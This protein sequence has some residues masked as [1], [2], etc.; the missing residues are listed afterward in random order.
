MQTEVQRIISQDSNGIYLIPKHKRL[1]IQLSISLGEK[2][3]HTQETSFPFFLS[4]PRTAYT[5]R[6]HK[7]V[8]SHTFSNLI[9]IAIL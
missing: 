3:Q 4:L 6:W 1:A 2:N 5:L 8:A 9:P 7:N